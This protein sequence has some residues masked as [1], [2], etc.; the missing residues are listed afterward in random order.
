MLVQKS[1]GT[2]PLLVSLL[3]LGLVTAAAAAPTA[4]SIPFAP[5]GE[6]SRRALSVPVPLTPESYLCAATGPD[7][8][9][10]TADDV[11]LLVSDLGTVPLVTPLPTP[12]L[13]TS[14]GSLTRM[15]A[16]RA[17][18]ISAGAD[19]VYTTPDDAVLLLD[20]LG[21]GNTVTP[22]VVGGLAGEHG[23]TPVRL[24]AESAVLPTHGPDLAAG[25]ADDTMVLLSDLGGANTVTPLLAPRL[26]SNRAIP[27]ALSP[28]SFLVAANG[29]DGSAGTADDQVYLFTGVGTT[30]TRTD[31]SVPR[32]FTQAPRRPV[33]VSPV[34]ALMP[35]AGPDGLE[36]T[37]DDEL[38]LLDNLGSTNDVTFIPV[39]HVMDFGAGMA[40]PLSETTAL[41]VTE[42]P[43]SNQESSDDQLAV[44]TGL[45][46]TNTVTLVT[47]GGLD[48]DRQSRPVR[49]S[50]DR[51]VLA[52]GGPNSTFDNLDDEA[53]VISGV[54]TANTIT[55]IPLPGLSRQS[56][57][58]P[59][60]VSTSSF[61]LS[62]GGPD[63]RVDAGLDD[64]I[65]L[66]QGIG[67]LISVESV[68]AAG[69]FNSTSA[70]AIPQLLGRG[71]AVAV[72]SGPNGDLGS[73]GD[74]VMRLVSGLPE[75]RFVDVRRLQ[76]NYK[77]SDPLGAESFQ[78]S[79]IYATDFA[80]LLL[81]QDVT[82]SVGNAA[83]T[84]PASS[85]RL[86]K[87]ELVYRDARRV[88]G[89]VTELGLNPVRGTFR[90]KGRGSDTGIRSTP[91]GYVPFAVQAGDVYLSDLVATRT[92]SRGLRFP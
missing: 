59:Q 2:A 3:L 13:P 45:G 27:T 81:G 33:R 86:K 36:S 12:Y 91:A 31:I 6:A 19:G 77:A 69:E 90:L 66:V 88:N 89:F 58:D 71:R 78:V 56:T 29:L 79:G 67:G 68:P 64:Q 52:T 42:G 83:Q 37:A 35:A 32:Q 39:P 28:T 30:H 14:S 38:V 5:H 82:V 65:T 34:R 7:G 75:V 25:T 61:V 9:F 43:D 51:V 73:G 74:D 62:H 26:R 40:V 16:T 11:V 85:F 92:V 50:G 15:S 87:G 1:R 54:G 23:F 49:M 47:V 18:V 10:R 63:G 21:S 53:V 72:S 46:T 44:I 24:T 20:Q 70:T 55:R 48:E 57:S 60:P 17:L 22:I 76:I 4:I 8:S 84:I 80:G 41:V